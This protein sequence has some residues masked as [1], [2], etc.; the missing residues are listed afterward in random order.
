[1]IEKKETLN[2]LK[3]QTLEHHNAMNPMQFLCIELLQQS[4]SQQQEI[5]GQVFCDKK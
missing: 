3:K 4:I 5:E 1:M 2:N